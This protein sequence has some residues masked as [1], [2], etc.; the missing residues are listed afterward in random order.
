MNMK[1]LEFHS[2]CEVSLRVLSG[3]SSHCSVSLRSWPRNSHHTHSD[4]LRCRVGGFLPTHVGFIKNIPRERRNLWVCKKETFGKYFFSGRIL[5]PHLRAAEGRLSWSRTWSAAV[6]C[7]SNTGPY[8]TVWCPRWSDPE[9]HVPCP[10]SWK[11]SNQWN[12]GVWLKA[13][14]N[15]PQLQLWQ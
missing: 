1:G 3:W 4:W 8:Q 15:F 2:E 7:H 11:S 5:F 14:I 12:S 6:W 10:N 13:L 9:R